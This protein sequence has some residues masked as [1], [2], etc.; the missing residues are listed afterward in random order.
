MYI[1]F[2][3]DCKYLYIINRKPIDRTTH[4]LEADPNELDRMRKE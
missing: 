2:T 4:V 3:S 1:E